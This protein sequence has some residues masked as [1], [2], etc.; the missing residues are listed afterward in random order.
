MATSAGV[1]NPLQS[2]DDAFRLVLF[3]AAA[4]IAI[5]V[6]VVLVDVVF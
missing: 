1:R 3:I 5:V 4:L 6:I 2:E